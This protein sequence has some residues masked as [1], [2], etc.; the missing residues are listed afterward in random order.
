MSI[1]SPQTLVSEALNEVKTI[2]PEEAMKLNSE[3]KCNL[4]DIRDGV[5]LQKLGAIENSFHIPRGLLEFSIHPESAYVQ[6]NQIDLN[7]ETVLFCAAGGRSALA[8]KTLKEMGF[9][10]VSHIKGGFSAMKSKGFK[11]T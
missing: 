6:N 9:K 10:K 7:K 3:N 1:K 8:A 11:I 4:I 2:T 5:E